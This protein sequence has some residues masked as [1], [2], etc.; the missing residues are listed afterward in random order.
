VAQTTQAR[1]G[2]RTRGS[3]GKR[4]DVG[5]LRAVSQITAMCALTTPTSPPPP[6]P[7]LILFPSPCANP[8]LLPL[9][10]GAVQVPPARD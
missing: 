5:W 8:S 1:I 4:S 10:S 3:E 9:P 6:P 2:R 7:V